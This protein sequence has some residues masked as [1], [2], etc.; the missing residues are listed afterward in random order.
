MRHLIFGGLAL[1]HSLTFAGDASYDCAHAS[2][3]S[4]KEIC[5]TPYLGKLD[6]EISELYKYGM[7]TLSP[8]KQDVL[9]T[10]QRAW[11]KGRETPFP[12][13]AIYM[14]RRLRV[15]Y[16]FMTAPEL[17]VES[18]KGPEKF[19]FNFDHDTEEQFIPDHVIGYLNGI[20]KSFLTEG[21]KIADRYAGITIEE[22]NKGKPMSVYFGPARISGIEMGGKTHCYEIW[23]LFISLSGKWSYLR[24]YFDSNGHKVQINNPVIANAELQQ[25]EE[26]GGTAKL[27]FWM[28]A[29]QARRSGVVGE[30]QFVETVYNKEKHELVELS[31]H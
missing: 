10:N 2:T 13:L 15:L 29:E 30:M 28:N 18:Y 23:E 20:G 3:K 17:K 22:F 7:K 27:V 26:F 16:T 11:I 25:C 5:V 8:K 4:E 24:E 21:A 9:I 19:V 12:N 6:K 14:E 1:L 31:K